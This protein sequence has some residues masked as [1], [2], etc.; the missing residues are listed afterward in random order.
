M[1]GQ[2]AIG[3]DLQG[4]GYGAS[5]TFDMQV[6]QQHWW[7]QSEAGGVIERELHCVGR[8]GWQEAQVKK[9]AAELVD[10][11]SSM[12]NLA[13]AATVAVQYLADLDNGVSLL[14]QAREWREALR[15]AYK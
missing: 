5:F 3:Y 7:P 1:Q 6:Q 11:L 8:L 9:L 14:T 15:V 2:G 13:G 12:G 4:G 10:G